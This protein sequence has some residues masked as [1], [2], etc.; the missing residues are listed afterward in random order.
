V[1][2][3]QRNDNW[4]V[5]YYAH[6]RRVR[7]KVGPSKGEALRALSVRKAEVALGKFNLIPRASIPTFKT[8]AER[9]EE[10]VSIHKKG[11]TGEHYIIQ[12]FMRIFGN[13]RI[14]DITAEDGERFKAVRSG[15][16]KPAT[17]NREMTVFKH[18]MSKALEWKLLVAN[19]LRGVRSLN[20]PKRLERILEV[21]EELR[22]LSACDHVRSKFLRP[23]IVLA[24]NT[25]MRRGELLSLQWS[26]VNFSRR[27]IRILNAKTESGERTIPMNSMT[28]AA[29]S[30]LKRNRKSELVFPSNR[31]EGKRIL[32]LKKGFKKAVREAELHGN[33]R[34][35]DLRHTFA[36]RLVQAGVDIIT[37]QHLLGHARISMTARYAHSPDTSRIAAV[38]QLDRLFN[39]KP[40]PNRPPGGKNRNSGWLNKPNRVNSLG[41]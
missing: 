13:R 4:F 7:E 21:N 16:V 40:A 8:F 29:L 11:R 28:Y 15:Q 27:K 14:S 33:L 39:T 36:T 30:S 23:V 26:Q 10:L 2:V 6:G 31:K 18:M 12:M 19:P 3:F 35:H 37:V 22:L 24:L 32:D 25:G 17:V 1:G 5:D 9:Y 38:E 34:F 41:S 20:V